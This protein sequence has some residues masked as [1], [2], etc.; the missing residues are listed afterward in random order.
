MVG[1]INFVIIR[2]GTVFISVGLGKI[3]QSMNVAEKKEAAHGMSPR[4]H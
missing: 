2:I 1:N 4:K 3:S